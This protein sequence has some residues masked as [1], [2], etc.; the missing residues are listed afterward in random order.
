MTAFGETVGTGGSRRRARSLARGAVVSALACW[1]ACTTPPSAAELS[2]EPGSLAETDDYRLGFALGT[3]LSERRDQGAEVRL[4]SVLRGLLDAL[5]ATEP[6]PKAG[7]QGVAGTGRKG[8]FVDDFAALNALRPGVVSL[9]SGVQYEV[10]AAGTGRQPGPSD[11]VGI[12]YQGSLSDGTRFDSTDE[13]GAPLDLALE[14][15]VVPGLREALLLMREGDRWRVVIPPSMGFGR[16]GNN[17]LRKRDLIYEIELVTVE[18][19]VAP[20]DG[21]PDP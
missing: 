4:D 18:P 8:G 10:L 17:L 20:L 9:P 12:R 15:I 1:V 11:R 16:S 3:Q 21:E 5:A 6:A 7:P 2:L 14:E 13:D 19:T